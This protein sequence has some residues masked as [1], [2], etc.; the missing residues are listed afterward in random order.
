MRHSQK[1]YQITPTLFHFTCFIFSNWQLDFL[2]S[3]IPGL[4]FLQK[5]L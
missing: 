1:K 2:N 4:D 3:V 5:Y